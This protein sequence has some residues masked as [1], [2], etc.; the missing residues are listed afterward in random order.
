MTEILL[1][2]PAG[3]ARTAEQAAL[4]YCASLGWPVAPGD[5]P[6]CCPLP[7]PDPP[8]ATT[9]DQVHEAWRGLPHATVHA[10]MGSPVPGAVRLAALDVPALVGVAALERIGRR[11]R[12]AGPVTDGG[13]RIRFL[14]DAG[15]DDP[16]WPVLDLWRAAGVDLNVAV[17][18][19]RVPLPTPGWKGAGAVVWAQPPDPESTVLPPLEEVARV[20]DRAVRDAYPALWTVLRR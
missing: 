19:S 13:G 14:V 18:G 5:G 16:W 17:C 9:P 8:A 7:A 11:P 10:V 12:A 6:D 15:P 3:T 20:V 1:P 2:V 4:W